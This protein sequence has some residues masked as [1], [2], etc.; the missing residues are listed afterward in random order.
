MA[1]P[2]K[3]R[4]VVDQIEMVGDEMTAYINRKTG[5][6]ITLTNEDFSYAEEHDASSLIPDWQ[7]ERGCLVKQ[8]LADDE[9]IALP[10][11]FEIH[12]Y[13]IMEHF[14][15][16][17]EDERVRNTL[18]LA[19][20]GKGAFRRFKDRVFEEA[21]DANWRRFR[22]SA[23]KQIAVGFLENQGIAYTDYK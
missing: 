9:F 20:N 14:C 4:A 7:K 15:Y 12:E 16:T 8:V 23:L 21:V 19:I 3:L 1:L 18:L 13:Q 6:L 22:D 17:I 10:D 2:V 5:D 11:S